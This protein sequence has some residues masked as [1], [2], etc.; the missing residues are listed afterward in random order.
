MVALYLCNSFSKSTVL[1]WSLILFQ[2]IALLRVK[3]LKTPKRMRL[4]ARWLHGIWWRL[5][6]KPYPSI[7]L[8]HREVKVT[9]KISRQSYMAVKPPTR[10]TDKMVIHGSS[11]FRY[12][13]MNCAQTVVNYEPTFAEYYAKKE[14]KANSTM[15]LFLILPRNFFV[16]FL[17]FKQ[18]I[19][20]II[21]MPWD[22]S[23]L[24]F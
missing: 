19:L 13:L 5:E 9:N 21:L 3:L 10:K 12:A 22:K 4:I 6:Y 15:L 14:S 8:P 20:F 2:S 16:S 1:L 17:P 18:K 11:Y 24:I 23:T 7:I